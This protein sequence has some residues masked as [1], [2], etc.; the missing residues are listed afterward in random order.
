MDKS[1]KF[2]LYPSKHQEDILNQVLESCRFLY[3]HQLEYERYVYEKEQRFANRVELNNIL[4]DVKI[5]NPIFKGIHSQ[6]LQNVNDRVIKAFECFF[7]RVKQGQSGY[8]RFNGKHRY[9]SFTY[10]QS[11]FKFITQSKLRLSKIGV[12]PI[13]LH[14]NTVGLTGINACGVA[15]LEA[16]MNQ[17]APSL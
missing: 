10:P 16:T 7:S 4:P 3:N 15:S 5:V 1:Y 6:I 14:S 13:K 9:N 2:R 11:G 12:L 17:E 8:P